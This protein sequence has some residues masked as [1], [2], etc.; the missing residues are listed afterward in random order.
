MINFLF[1]SISP[2]PMQC[3]LKEY[4]EDV[5]A[6]KLSILMAKRVEDMKLLGITDDCV[7]PLPLNRYLILL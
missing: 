6:V 5:T 4:V 1:I 7:Y 2:I 3:V